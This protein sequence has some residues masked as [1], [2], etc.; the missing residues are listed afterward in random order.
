VTDTG[1]GRRATRTIKVVPAPDWVDFPGAA[2]VA[3]GPPDR[4]QA[5]ED[6]RRGCLPDH[7]S[8]DHRRV[9]GDGGRVGPRPLGQRDATALRQR[10]DLGEDI[11]TVRTGQSPRVMATLRNTAISLLR[12][13][14]W[15]NIAKALRHHARDPERALTCL[16]TC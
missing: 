1:H 11:S 9:P 16:L 4:D 3:Q 2:Q 7:L 5:G 14:G 10:R 12:L 15:D 8:R 6:D 13:A